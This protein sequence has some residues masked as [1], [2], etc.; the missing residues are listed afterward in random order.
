MFVFVTSNRRLMTHV[1]EKPERKPGATF[2]CVYKSDVKQ[3]RSVH[4]GDVSAVQSCFL[5]AY[6]R[7]RPKL[8]DE[9]L[10]KHGTFERHHVILGISI[11][12]P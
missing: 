1:F 8:N 2:Q 10:P 9:D 3:T 4:P 11:C 7:Q 5:E 12:T 6:I